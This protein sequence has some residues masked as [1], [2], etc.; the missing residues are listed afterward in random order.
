[1]VTFSEIWLLSA[2]RQD[3]ADVESLVRPFGI[4]LIWYPQPASPK[5]YQARSVSESGAVDLATVASAL[6]KHSEAFEI[7][8]AQNLLQFFYH[9]GLGLKTVSI[10]SAGE[11]VVRFTQL[12]QLRQQSAGSS[13]EY[14][15]LLRLARAQAWQDALE[16]LRRGWVELDGLRA[17]I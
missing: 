14:E 2:Q 10:D 8:D 5:T 12:D 6:A 7:L 4:E 9:R 17:V 16:P 13:Y 11:T 1:L 15:R 3:L